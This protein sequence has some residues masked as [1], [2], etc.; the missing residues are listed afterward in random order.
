MRELPMRM[1]CILTICLACSGCSAVPSHETPVTGPVRGTEDTRTLASG[2]DTRIGLPSN[3]S[4]GFGWSLDQQASTGPDHVRIED[5]GFI[6]T[7]SGLIGAPGRRW[8]TV[9]AV[10]PGTSSLRFVYQRAWDR[11]TPPAKTRTV[12]IRVR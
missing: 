9:H 2:Q 1:G 12:V 4:T 8:W 10:R 11:T 7:D 5:V 6:S 3:P